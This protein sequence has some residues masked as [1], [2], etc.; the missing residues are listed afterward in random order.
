M[1]SYDAI[2]IG[3]GGVGSA[4]MWR[5]ARRGLSVLGIDRF[6]PPHE[7]GSSHGQTRIIRQAYFEHPDYVPLAQR[8]Y[9]LWAELEGLTGAALFER[10][11]VV[12]IGPPDGAVVRGVLLAAEAHGLGVETLDGAEVQRRWP[13]LRPPEGLVAVYEPTGGFLHVE[14]CVQACLD[15]ARSHG[16]RT[17][18]ETG[19]TGWRDDGQRLI[20]ATDGGDFATE[21]L[22]V[23]AGSWA[24]GLLRELDLRLQI[25]RKSLFWF[26]AP[27]DHAP[28]RLPPFLF[29]LPGGVFYG[30][31]DV[32]RAGVKVGDHSVGQPLARPEDIDRRI[33]PHEERAVRGFLSECLPRV[34]ATLTHHSTCY[35]TMSPDEHFIVDHWPGDPRI[36]LAAGLSGHG[37][38]FTPVLGEALAD[39]VIG[40]AT[41]LPVGFL[42]AARLG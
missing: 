21:R 36:A 42:G 22:I 39:L 41:P 20:V 17:L 18:C 9:A 27:E 3:A 19:V 2:V 30:I 29:E 33:A 13:Q 25:R 16:A 24:G 10:S 31:P 32:E 11:G 5:L 26:A 15:A 14:R 6:R 37:F 38:K 12:E 28:G 4:A 35:Y 8:A 7:S 34:T 40:G 1:D 23:T